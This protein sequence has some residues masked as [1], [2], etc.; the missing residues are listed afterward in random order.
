MPGKSPAFHLRMTLP[1]EYDMKTIVYGKVVPA[2]ALMIVI[3][4]ILMIVV[5]WRGRFR[6][7]SHVV[8]IGIAICNMLYMISIVIPSV[9]FYGLGFGNEYVPY[10]WCVPF[11]I[12][13]ISVPK[14]CSM[15]ALYLTALLGIHRF[16]I[17]SFPIKAKSI[18]KV[19]QTVC[20]V[21]VIIIL[22]VTVNLN[23]MLNLQHLHEVFV[24][25]A[26]ETDKVVSGCR[27]TRRP[28]NDLLVVLME[29][30]VILPISVLIIFNTL[31]IR[32]L[33]RTISIR[34]ELAQ[35]DD[36][37]E[38][39]K[40]MIVLTSAIVTSVIIVSVPDLVVRS[41]LYATGNQC[42]NCFVN[43]S[44]FTVYMQC[45]HMVTYSANF[46]IYSFL[47]K[48][49]RDAMRNFMQ[50]RSVRRNFNSSDQRYSRH[51]RETQ[52]AKM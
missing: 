21:I 34:R 27:W 11:H 23:R 32:L 14:I 3:L 20:I 37:E 1:E 28:K 4:N 19:K 9:Y 7:P 51:A 35:N 52:I 43:K 36:R 38:S 17:V 30:T 15:S 44:K 16:L 31:L 10:D 24:N 46:F 25:S 2:L 48:M 22:V 49:F 29:I 45:A 50:C 42:R 12:L 8:L 5:F 39:L 40:R 33:F 47:S 6:S 41:I 13:F 18:L 26:V